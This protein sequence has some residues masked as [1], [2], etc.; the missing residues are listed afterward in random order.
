MPDGQ[1]LRGKNTP[2]GPS[3]EE[4]LKDRAVRREE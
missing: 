4:W 2:N 1:I 3:F